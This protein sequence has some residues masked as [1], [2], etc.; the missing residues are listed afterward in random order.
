MYKSSSR[1]FVKGFTREEGE[2]EAEHDGGDRGCPEASSGG[3]SVE[4]CN[5]ERCNMKQ[6]GETKS[7]E[8]FCGKCFKSI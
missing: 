2:Q 4:G 5:M 1:H 6:V 8:L 7:S 3:T